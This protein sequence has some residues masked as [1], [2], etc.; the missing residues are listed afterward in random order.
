MDNTDPNDIEDIRGNPM[1][2]PDEWEPMTATSHHC[3]KA[4]TEQVVWADAEAACKDAVTPGMVIRIMI[5]F[6]VALRV[7]HRFH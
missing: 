6:F 3:Y 2:C 4:F 5:P 7:S 1:N